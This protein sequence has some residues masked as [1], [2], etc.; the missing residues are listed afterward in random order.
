MSRILLRSAVLLGLA[1]PAGGWADDDTIA[2][3]HLAP[4]WEGSTMQGESLFFLEPE[5]GA[6]AT[7]QLLFVP[8]LI[9]AVV[10]PA[11]GA[12][13]EAGRD[14]TVDAE[15]RRLTLTPDSRIPF[16]TRADFEPPLGKTGQRYRDDTRDIFFEN[17]HRFHDFQIEVTYEHDPSDWSRLNGPVPKPA[18]AQLPNFAKKLETAEPVTICL[19]GDSISFGLNASGVV[20]AAPLQP[21]YGTLFAEGI[22]ARFGCPVT[23]EN[24]SI[25]GK[26]T[27]WGLEMAPAVA[28]KEPDLVIIAFGMNDASGHLAPEQFLANIQKIVEA[29]RAGHAET[30][31]IL[32]ATMRGNA[33]WI[34]AAPDLYPQY[35]DILMTAEV[36][37][38]AVADMTSFWT[39]FLD[40]K[41][42]AD[43]TGNGVNHPNDF[44]HRVY[45]QILLAM[46]P[47][48]SAR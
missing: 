24:V 13:Y 45:A 21:A 12:V 6:P 27:G 46:F 38:V 1:L 31:F 41:T 44:G 22:Q 15:N 18:M 16:T 34:H 40:R 10:H 5:P 30:S 36:P 4:F 7:A 42:Y 29:I 20:G 14:F 47:K 35:R 17:E 33:D 26:S 48:A 28:E 43:I 11:T 3:W 37:G 9:E 2:R 23:Y 25:S 39:L 8:K 32:V 19:L